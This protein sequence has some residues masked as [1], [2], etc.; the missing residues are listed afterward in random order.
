[1]KQIR[2]TLTADE[3][4]A[5]SRFLLEK[6]IG[7]RV[8]PVDDEAPESGRTGTV[9]PAGTRRRKAPARTAKRGAKPGTLGS[10]GADRLREALARTHTAPAPGPQESPTELGG[11]TESRRHDT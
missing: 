3:F 10:S 2:L 7:F 1:M 11:P 4:G 9:A 5:I 6:G 8:E